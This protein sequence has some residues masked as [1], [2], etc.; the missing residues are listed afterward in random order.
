MDNLRP[1]FQAQSNPPIA[2]VRDLMTLA[3]HSWV[4]KIDM[5]MWRV[6]L[7]RRTTDLAFR[8]IVYKRVAS[9]SLAR[10][11]WFICL[12]DRCVVIWVFFLVISIAL[13]T[14]TRTNSE[15]TVHIRTSTQC[16]T[17][18]ILPS[19]VYSVA[20]VM[21]ANRSSNLQP[22]HRRTYTDHQRPRSSCANSLPHSR[23]TNVCW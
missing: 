11:T 15:W 10:I 3:T 13:P 12:T 5:R 20:C 8:Y 9:A 7:T 16:N 22:R 18:T 6:A 1:S 19:R 21:G 17:T 2:S 23:R 4:S 14:H